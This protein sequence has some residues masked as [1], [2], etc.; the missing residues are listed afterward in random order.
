MDAQF[1]G[2]L[3]MACSN[4]SGEAPSLS[5]FSDRRTPAYNLMVAGVRLKS[6]AKPFLKGRNQAFLLDIRG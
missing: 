1:S 3:S 6:F 2:L 4:A 5:A